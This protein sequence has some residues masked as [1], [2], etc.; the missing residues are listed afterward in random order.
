MGEWIRPSSGIGVHPLLR[1]SA[2]FLGSDLILVETTN[3]LKDRLSSSIEEDSSE[4]TT[5]GL[6][7]FVSDCWEVLGVAVKILQEQQSSSSLMFKSSINQIARL[8]IRALDMMVQSPEEQVETLRSRGLAVF[9][10]LWTL[11]SHPGRVDD[12]SMELI[13]SLMVEVFAKGFPDL[14]AIKLSQCLVNILVGGQVP[15]G[16]EH[17]QLLKVVASGPALFG[18]TVGLLMGYLSDNGWNR[19]LLRASRIIVSGVQRHLKD[20]EEPKTLLLYPLPLQPLVNLVQVLVAEEDGRDLKDVL[21]DR[22]VDLC[23]KLLVDDNEGHHHAYLLKVLLILCYPK[24]LGPILEYSVRR[25][26]SLHARL[27]PTF[28]P[29]QSRPIPFTLRQVLYEPLEED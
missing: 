23:Q 6:F 13:E 2:A 22:V 26:K 7:D 19:S 15:D 8:G 1:R 4:G 17:R 16:F 21:M 9:D 5:K 27:L 28:F 3:R 14:F 29:D 24:A 11:I 18:Q 12:D 25:R 10:D 20:S